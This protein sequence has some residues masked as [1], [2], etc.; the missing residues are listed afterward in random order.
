MIRRPPRSTLFPYTTLF[1][2]REDS[3]KNCWEHPTF[4][5]GFT[6]IFGNKLTDLAKKMTQFAEQPH[7]VWISH[8]QHSIHG[9][10]HFHPAHIT[11]HEA[12]TVGFFTKTK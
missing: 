10:Y 4:G 7:I 11:N 6:R 8:I 1:R 2:S 12:I 9:D 5:I 3:P